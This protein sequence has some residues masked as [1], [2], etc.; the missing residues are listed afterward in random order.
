MIDQRDIAN[1]ST[2][3]ECSAAEVAS[4]ELQPQQFRVLSLEEV[5][6][7]A[8]GPTINNEG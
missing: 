8:G 4:K 7:V 6:A 3:D 1:F 5:K 2:A